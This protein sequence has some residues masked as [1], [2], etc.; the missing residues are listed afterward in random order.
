M[1]YATSMYIRET[2]RLYILPA[3]PARVLGESHR[4]GVILGSGPVTTSSLII[5]LQN[6]RL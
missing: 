5:S 3:L 4:G 2:N 6:D 1:H